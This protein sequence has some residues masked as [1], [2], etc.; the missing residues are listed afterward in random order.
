MNKNKIKIDYNDLVNA[1][2]LDIGLYNPYFDF[3]DKY[4]LDK[5]HLSKSNFP[6]PIIISSKKKF[7]NSN[8]ISMIYKNKIIG[9]IKI[10]K[11]FKYRKQKLIKIMF[12]LNK[13][14]HKYIK[15]YNNKYKINK[16]FLTG[17]VKLNKKNTYVQKIY[18]NNLMLKK[19][20]KEKNSC[21]FSTRN[22]PH[23]G[24]NLIQ[25]KILKEKKLL[26]VCFIISEKNKYKTE[27]LYKTYESLK[28]NYSD[29]KNIKIKHIYLP[30]YFGGPKE[31][32]L[33]AKIFEN[34]GFKSFAVGRDHA[35]Y[36]GLYE[37]YSSQNYL[38]KNKNLKIEI[39]SNKEPV[40]C[41][42][43]KKV[44]FLTKELDKKCLFCNYPLSKIDGTTIK[45]YLKIKKLD[46]AKRYLFPKVYLC[47]KK[48]KIL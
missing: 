9:Q 46:A 24:H 25:G 28:K 41:N 40:L 36:I 27:L 8:E 43:C 18:R 20:L 7:H 1:I 26:Y 10:K 44:Q 30:T 34:C 19:I 31:A 2:N 6:F 48:Y 35:G 23:V 33:Q 39:L 29:F 21:V 3:F 15:Y 17:K 4:H 37:K 22:I 12:G 11:I 42:N 47:V 32:F 38:K 5:I 45:K 16:Y 13:L 14:K